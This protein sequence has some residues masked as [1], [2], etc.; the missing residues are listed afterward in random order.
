VF[1]F[2]GESLRKI[3]FDHCIL[4]GSSSILIA[5]ALVEGP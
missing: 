5:D 1:I 2:G 3:I 4:A